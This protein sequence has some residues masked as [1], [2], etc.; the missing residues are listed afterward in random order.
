MWH[1]HPPAS[2]FDGIQPSNDDSNKPGTVISA[3]ASGSVG[4]IVNKSTVSL[5]P[6]HP[7]SSSTGEVGEHDEINNTKFDPNYSSW[8]MDSQ[9]GTFNKNVNSKTYLEQ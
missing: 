1:T 5:F 9:K 8:K 6:I 7:L 3:F 4:V 2:S